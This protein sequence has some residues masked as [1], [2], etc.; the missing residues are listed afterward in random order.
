[1]ERRCASDL[2]I[3]K[4]NVETQVCFEDS[5]RGH[6]VIPVGYPCLGGGRF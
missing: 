6:Y 4:L 1:M 5:P 2:P 3:F